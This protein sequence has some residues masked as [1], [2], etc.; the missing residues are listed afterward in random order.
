M[1]SSANFIL[2]CERAEFCVSLIYIS[3]IYNSIQ[4]HL[5]QFQFPSFQYR[6]FPQYRNT[7]KTLTGFIVFTESFSDLLGIRD[8]SRNLGTFGL[9]ISGRIIKRTTVR[10][11]GTCPHY[12]ETPRY[13]EALQARDAAKVEGFQGHLKCAHEIFHSRQTPVQF[14]QAGVSEST[15]RPSLDNSGKV[16]RRNRLGFPYVLIVFFFTCLIFVSLVFVYFIFFGLVFFSFFCLF[17]F[18]QFCVCLL[19]YVCLLFFFVFCLTPVSYLL[20][21]NILVFFPLIFLITNYIC[22][23]FHENTCRNKLLLIL[24]T[25]N[26]IEVSL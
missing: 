2:D 12:G 8:S 25:L 15:R 7:K 4:Y 16:R 5:V 19:F 14:P 24:I 13:H 26:H 20:F 22:T 21:D 18:C 1:V 11:A 9:I 6:S 23:E 3:L 10:K 17:V